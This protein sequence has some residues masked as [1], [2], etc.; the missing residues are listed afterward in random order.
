MEESIHFEYA[1]YLLPTTASLTQDATTLLRQS[2]PKY[3]GLIVVD[4]LPKTPQAMFVYAHVN[5]N[6][7]KS[8]APPRVES[9][10]RFGRG[11]TE[12]Q[13]K[14]LQQSTSALLLDFAHPRKDV[15]AALR[16]ASG[17]V[18]EIAR[19]SG[20]LV[21]DEET[22][23]VF[24]PDAWHQKRL[25]SWTNEIPDV[26]T[27]TVIHIYPNGEYARAITLGMSKIGLPD[28]VVE[29]SSWSSDNQVGN[30]INI[31][32]QALAETQRPLISSNFRLDL[33]AIKNVRLRENHVK[34]LKPN[35]AGVA[36]LS[37]AEGK[38]EEGDP[39]NRLVR[40]ASDE[41]PG[42][43]SHAQQEAML[44]SF[45]GWED[46]MV[47]V[48]DN[49]E[50]LVASTKAKGEL[51]ELRKAFNA[52]LE[53]GEFIEVKAPFRAENGATEWMWVEVTSWKGDRIKGVLNND[54]EE[55]ANLR[56]GQIVEVR[57][58]DVFDYL[59]N[60]ADKHT[61]GNTTGE[62]IRKMS[63]GE[64]KNPSTPSA[65]PACATK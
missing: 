21:W 55:V 24:S 65:V 32:S 45:F 7:K 54:P 38:W 40:L 27:Q 10:R 47:K 2:L 12:D 60:Y 56:A 42:N 1:V 13:A 20:G 34:S 49:E 57:E 43:D 26:S 19:K 64:V 50:L 41:Y 36:C 14:A 46:S 9:L 23:E 5:K 48:H 4:E 61:E 59:H 11:L 58:G 53:P 62:I 63:E 37:L 44:S 17:L 18:E 15:W 28:V 6:V 16:T 30:L 22:R 3:P 35:A 33:H 52:G 31:F 8:Y 25:A 39:K 29:E 51:P